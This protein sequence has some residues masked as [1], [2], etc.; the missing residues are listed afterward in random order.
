MENN[1]KKKNHKL[2]TYFTFVILQKKNCTSD[3]KTV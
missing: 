3:E 1:N 2:I